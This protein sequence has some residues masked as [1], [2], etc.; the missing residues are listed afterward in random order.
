MPLLLGAWAAYPLV[1]SNPGEMTTGLRLAARCFNPTEESLDLESEAV[2][3][4]ASKHLAP[5]WLDARREDPSIL[6][7]HCI[8]NGCTGYYAGG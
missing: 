2:N 7:S 1:H 4:L 8:P 5:R 6:G 3:C